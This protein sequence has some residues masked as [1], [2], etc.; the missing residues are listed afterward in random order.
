M[1]LIECTLADVKE[2]VALVRWCERTSKV[3]QLSEMHPPEW[4]KRKCRRRGA[5][6]GLRTRGSRN[7]HKRLVRRRRRDSIC[8]LTVPVRRAMR[9]GRIRYLTAV[10]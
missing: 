6:I 3:E 2:F 8:D 1:S 7:E 5:G 9:A 4:G 10:I